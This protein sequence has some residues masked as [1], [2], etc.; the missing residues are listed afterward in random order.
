[1][2]VTRRFTKFFLICACRLVVS[3]GACAQTFPSEARFEQ[4]RPI[5]IGPTASTPAGWVDFC[6]RYRGECDMPPRVAV[7]IA[8][9]ST[10]RARIERINISVN[11][12]I[13][14]VSDLARWGLADQWDYPIDDKG[15][16][17]DF[18][19]LKRRLLAAEAVP[20]GALLVTVVK[21]ARN[22]GHAVLTVKTDKG[23]FILDNLNDEMKPWDRT[24]Y[25]FVKRQ[26]QFDPNHW[27]QLGEP[28]SSPEFVSRRGPGA[29][30]REAPASPE[31]NAA[32]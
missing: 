25:R 27:V 3:T 31:E 16:C 23:D 15:D 2:T 9:D 29:L 30:R 8:L 18:V 22:D 32:Q 4:P 26:S 5:R 20:P 24:G 11:Q 10:L 21:D 13:V 19:L 6:A 7:D 14:P 17:E 1:M 28:T 12:S